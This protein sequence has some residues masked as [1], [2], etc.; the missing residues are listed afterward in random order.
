MRLKRSAAA[1][2][3]ASMLAL[4]ACGGG[5]GGSEGSGEGEFQEGGGAGA[6]KNPDAQGPV[7]VPE[8]AQ[9][10]GT[11]TILSDEAPAT[12][13]PT[14]TYYVDSAA[15]M[16]LVTRSLTTYKYDPETNDMVLVPDLAEGLGQP[17]EDFTEWTFTLKEGIKYGDGTPVEPEHVAYAI[18]RSFA[19][20][21]LPDGPTYQ[22]EYFLNGDTYKGPY[23]DGMDYEGVEVDG[24]DITIKM[25]K[26][27]NAMDYY[28]SFPIFTPIPPERDDPQTYGN[29]PLATGPYKFE[30]YNPGTS[31]TLTRNE[32]WDPETDPA[33]IQAVD[34]WE[35]KFGQDSTRLQNVIYG[36][37]GSAQTTA[38]YDNAQAAILRKFQQNAQDRLT[39]GS[40]PCTY[41]WY[42]D[43][44]KI[45]D[46]KVR[47]AI[48]LAYPTREV[49][50][51]TGE[52]EGYTRKPATTIL[53]PGTNGRQEYDVLGTGGLSDNQE[54]ARQLLEEAGK[55]GY[56]LRWF[57]QSDDAESVRAKDTVVAAMKEAGFKPTPIASTSATI[58]DEL[59]DPQAD[60]NI[61]TGTGWCSD[62]PSGGSW[63]PA[64]WDGDL[65]SKSSVP[66]PSF[67]DKPDVNEEI[68][69]IATEESPETAPEAWGELGQYIMEKYY[70]ALPTGY[71]AGAFIRGSKVG[72]FNNDTTLGMPTFTRMYITQ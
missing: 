66:N 7:P 48:G 5:G 15:I 68:D 22:L 23:Q 38:T 11:I 51:A 2:A 62:W 69:R 58:R 55:V 31:L 3:T 64:Q 72:G 26:P 43:M 25:A 12:F 44:R 40:S 41:F 27:F 32:F 21:E 28:A 36:D 24:Q 29:K 46:I 35:F 65:I 45:T 33:R 17:N 39:T 53:P 59:N 71:S 47:K 4:A 57:Y 63:F 14:R 19:V 60:I 37:Q 70:P 16:R 10:G 50:R 18:K 61:H 8:D 49:W 52:V 30:E 20:E 67:L 54:K 34:R 6:A 9:D 42:F 13:D 1:L 56:E